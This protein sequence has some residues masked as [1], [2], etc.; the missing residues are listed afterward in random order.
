VWD[1]IEVKGPLTIKDLCSKFESEYKV[2]V[3]IISCGKISLYQS[4][5]PSNQKRKDRLI[6]DLIR[7]IGSDDLLKGKTNIPINVSCD[8][9]ETG[10]CVTMPVIKYTFK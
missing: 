1:K 2:D 7:E 9:K 10:D 6:E 4:F 8:D 5:I 3:S